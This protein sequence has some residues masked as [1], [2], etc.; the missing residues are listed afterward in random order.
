[1]SI[2][3]T[4][5]TS[6]RGY[7][8]NAEI[9]E[10]IGVAV[11]LIDDKKV[12]LAEQLVDDYCGYWEKYMEN[13]MEG[14]ASAGG[15]LTL[16]LNLPDQNVYGNNYLT[17][18]EIEIIG[19]TGA[20]QRRKIVSSTKAG[21]VTVDT[22]WT[23]QPDSTSYYRIYQLG[24]FPRKCDRVPYES[25]NETYYKTIPEAV[26]RAVCAQYEYIVEMG[27][28]YF[29][30]DKSA[31][32]SES[33]GDYSYQRQGSSPSRRSFLGAKAQSMLQG[34]VKRYGQIV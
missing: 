18:C 28:A 29:E 32:Q 4:T 34:L 19:G 24:T 6:R 20:G 30:T 27:D 16:T 26:R 17:F 31:M 11:N 23:T 21:V 25:T 10:Y 12:E 5:P 3:S 9:A 7:A 2:T 1:M 15:S 8:S 14:L 33:I 22:A 13:Q